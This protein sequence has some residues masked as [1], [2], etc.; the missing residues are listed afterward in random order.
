M[1]RAPGC[2]A[3]ARLDGPGRCFLS[4]TAGA[5]AGIDASTAEQLE[6]RPRR[7]DVSV[8]FGITEPPHL[9]L[10]QGDSSRMPLGEPAMER[11]EEVGCLAVI[12]GPKAREHRRNARGKKRPGE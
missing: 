5:T 3:H 8:R 6:G 2:P 12:D 11:D 7:H 10:T 9:R 4:L 1:V